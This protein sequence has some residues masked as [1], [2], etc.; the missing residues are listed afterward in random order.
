MKLSTKILTLM[1]LLFTA[2]LV[3][4]NV[5]LKK[6]YDKADKSDLYW[7]YGKILQEPFR[8]IS[9]EGGNVTNIAFEQ[10]NKPSVRV[11]KNWE[12]YKKRSVQ[13]IVKND[14]LFLK[15]PNTYKDIYEKHWM[16]G[17]TLVRV[18]SPQILSVTGTDT[19]FEMFKMKQKSISVIM[20]GKSSFELE[21]MIQ[22]FDSL[23]IMQN[24]S[25]AVVFEMS[26]DF[27]VSESF[28]A[29]WVDASI[30]GFSILDLG[31]AQVDSLHLTIADSSAILLSGGTLKKK[32]SLIDK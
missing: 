20:A 3:A 17:N 1:L 6:E 13:A 11:Y 23:H 18:F 5:L 8:H 21:S 19:K 12:G 26:P 10:N 32:H 4:S 15:F 14:T 28:H 24:D 2:G 30:K 16:G 27:K 29:K 22:E 31:H 7:N 25:S 9:I